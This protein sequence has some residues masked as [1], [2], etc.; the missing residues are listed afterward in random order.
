MFSLGEVAQ[1]MHTCVSKC[2][3]NEKKNSLV[4]VTHTC[5]STYSRGRAQEDHSSKP[6]G[7]NSAREH[8]SKKKKKKKSSSQKRAGGM[9]QVVGP[10]FKLQYW[11]KKNLHEYV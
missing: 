4:L 1:I 7:S 2:K 10:E 3:I 8:I 11:K 6:A 9:L 5:N